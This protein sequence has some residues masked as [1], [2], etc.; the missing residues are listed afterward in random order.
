PRAPANTGTESAT[1]RGQRGVAPGAAAL[2]HDHGVGHPT[3]GKPGRDPAGAV[4]RERL[5]PLVV[6]TADARRRQFTP[7]RPARWPGPGDRSGR[8]ARNATA[9]TRP[10]PRAATADTHP[11]LRRGPHPG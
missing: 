11:A 2:A 10:T 9:P 1:G 4:L 7:A 5:P 3:R 8:P 6:R